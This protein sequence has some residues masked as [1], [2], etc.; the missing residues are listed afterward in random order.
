MI[1]DV[2]LAAVG[3][4]LNKVE[5]LSRPEPQWL[6]A[7]LCGPALLLA[8]QAPFEF[9]VFGRISRSRLA[10]LLALAS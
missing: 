2:V 10:G 8:G 1:A 5:P 6:I 7:I 4:E 9:Q 3:F